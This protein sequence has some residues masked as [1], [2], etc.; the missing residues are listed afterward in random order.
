ML[1]VLLKTGD[2]LAIRRPCGRVAM[3][4]ARRHHVLRARAAYRFFIDLRVPAAVGAEHNSV[5]FGRPD[6]KAVP[7]IWLIKGQRGPQ[8]RGQVLNPDIAVVE[9]RASEISTASFR[10][11]G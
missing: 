4:F 7:L 9:V 8:T 6:G 3:S 2:E 5:S 10:P 11:S 1:R